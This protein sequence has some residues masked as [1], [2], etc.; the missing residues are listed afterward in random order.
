MLL[1]NQFAFGDPGAMERQI[2]GITRVSGEPF[3]SRVEGEYGISFARGRRVEIEFDEEK[4]VGGGVY[5]LASVLEQFLGLYASLNSF[6]TLAVRTQQREELLREWPPRAG[7]KS[8][9]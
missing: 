4:F 9:L 3:Y 1:L 5:L 8:L 2:Q 7:W 6:I